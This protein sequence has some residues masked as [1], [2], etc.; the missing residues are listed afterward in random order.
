MVLAELGSREVSGDTGVKCPLRVS[1]A[2][3]Q[4]WTADGA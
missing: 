1:Q 2:W 3:M 4:A